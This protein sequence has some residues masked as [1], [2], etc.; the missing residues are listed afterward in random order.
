M[1]RCLVDIWNAEV[2]FSHAGRVLMRELN[3]FKRVDDTSSEASGALSK[4]GRPNDS[5]VPRGDQGS[6]FFGYD[7]VYLVFLI[8]DV[9][10]TASLQAV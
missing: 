1:D 9:R 2:D 3:I 8:G 4:G 6:S 5:K 10:A 7:L